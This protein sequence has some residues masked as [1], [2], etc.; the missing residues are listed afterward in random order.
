MTAAGGL[1]LFSRF[2]VGMSASMKR[3][4]FTLTVALVL[5]AALP[6]M[7]AQAQPTRVFVAAQGSDANSCTFATP[8]RTFQHAND[9]VAAGGE[10][11]VLDPA[12]YGA[13][14]IN[15]AISI[16]GHGFAGLAALSGNAITINAGPNDLV[17]VRGDARLNLLMPT[18]QRQSA[19]VV[20]RIPRPT[21]PA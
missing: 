4:L 7:P 11:D 18:R 5:F 3:V 20:P 15:K 17:N 2:Q 13:L 16:Q 1:L 14:T 10:V 8:C 9:I 12:D 21:V 6:A 19:I